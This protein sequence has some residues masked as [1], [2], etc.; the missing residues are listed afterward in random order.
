MPSK[1]YLC[2]SDTNCQGQVFPRTINYTFK[3][4]GKEIT[5]PDVTVDVCDCCGEMFFP[6]EAARKIEVY[7]NYS[8]DIHLH[9]PPE[10]HTKL[11]N[12]AHQHHH[13]LNE[14]IRTIVEQQLCRAE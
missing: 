12:L 1:G 3:S 5:V 8:G 6:H 14:E 7:Q 2:P 9:F 4:H 10:V 13:S 11:A